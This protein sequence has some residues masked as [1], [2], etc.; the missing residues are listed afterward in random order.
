MKIIKPPKKPYVCFGCGKIRYR[1]RTNID[2]YPYCFRCGNFKKK[3]SEAIEAMKSKEIEHSL[4]IV[5]KDC[6][7]LGTC[8]ILEIHHHIMKSDPE[9]LSTEFMVNLI[10]GAEKTYE[11]LKSKKER[12]V[13]P[14]I[15][16]EL[17]VTE[18]A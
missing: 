3:E 7:I 9:R 11:Y 12:D 4:R 10:C 2:G 17:L 18:N 15:P 6:T 5:I 16:M 14:F 13:I 8:G 1:E